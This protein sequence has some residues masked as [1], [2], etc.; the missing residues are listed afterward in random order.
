MGLHGIGNPLITGGLSVEDRGLEEGAATWCEP[1]GNRQLAVHKDLKGKS[2]C[3][4]VGRK[5]LGSFPVEKAMERLSLS[6]DRMVVDRPCS[7]LMT[8]VELH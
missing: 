6:Q 8:G 4:S 7:R 3:W 2:G 1:S 5:P